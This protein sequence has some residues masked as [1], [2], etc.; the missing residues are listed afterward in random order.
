VKLHKHLKIVQGGAEPLKKTG[1]TCEADREQEFINYV[2]D[3]DMDVKL[4]IR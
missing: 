3:K 4:K 1:K 2:Y